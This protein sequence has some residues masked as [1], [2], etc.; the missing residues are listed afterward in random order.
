VTSDK[1]QT[2]KA[3]AGQDQLT[4][5]YYFAA[6]KLTKILL[7]SVIGWRQKDLVFSRTLQFTVEVSKSDEFPET[8]KPFM[9]ILC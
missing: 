3:W 5:Y 7:K 6:D 9:I 2:N 1:R 8:S 4:L